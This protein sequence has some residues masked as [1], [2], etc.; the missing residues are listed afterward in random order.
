MILDKPGVKQ[1]VKVIIVVVPG[2]GGNLFLVPQI[3]VQDGIIAFAPS[4]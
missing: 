2:L 1:P 4:A 3:S